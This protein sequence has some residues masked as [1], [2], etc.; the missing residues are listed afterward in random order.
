MNFMELLEKQTNVAI[1]ENGAIGYKTTFNPLLDFNFKVPSY[2][3]LPTQSLEAEIKN[4]IANTTDFESFYRYLFFLRDVRGGMG[5]R[6]IF[7]ETLRLLALKGRQE[8]K[9]LIPLVADYGRFDDLFSLKG[10]PFEEDMVDYIKSTYLSDLMSMS[11]GKKVTLLAKWLPSINASCKETRNLAKWFMGH[12]KESPKSYRQ[13]LSSLRKYANVVENQI[14]RGDFASIVYESVP[15]KA[16]LRYA[17]LFMKM[18]RERRCKFLE[19]VAKGEKKLKSSTLFPQDI[20]SRVRQRQMSATEL[21]SLWSGLRDFGDIRNV[22]VVVDVSGSM[23]SPV[24][25]NTVALDASVGLGA[26]FA[27]RNTG[28]FKDKIVTFSEKPEL[29]DLSACDNIV[30]KY[31]YMCKANWGMSTN[32]EAVFDLVL[33]TAKANKCSQEEIPSILIISDMEFN[34]CSR[35]REYD[36]ETISQKF[37]DCGYSLPKL[38]FWNVAGRTNTIPVIQNELGVAL[39]SGYSPASIGAVMSAKFDPYQALLDCINVERYDKVAE[40]IKDYVKA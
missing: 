33:E 29:V 27:E 17:D 24:D 9:A 25:S 40:T 26:Y 19:Q 1:T 16:N 23:Y 14:S 18:D 7:R 28:A 12:F 2:R 21:Q 22:L 13:H 8:V 37:K 6:R 11:T 36:F 4:L 34:A 15:S 32:I 20:I 30:D 38:S 39:I 3:Y 35:H 10:T 5:E 31:N